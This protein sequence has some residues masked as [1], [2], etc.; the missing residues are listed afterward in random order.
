VE[1]DHALRPIVVTTGLTDG[2]LTEVQGGDLAEGM[3]VVVG[4]QTS[5]HAA[6]A[7]GSVSPFAPQPLR[8][9]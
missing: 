8:G 4:E 3:G 9:R 2:T 6:A 1:Q 7:G 5:S